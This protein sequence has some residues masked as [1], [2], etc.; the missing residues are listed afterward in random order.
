MSEE[1]GREPTDEDLS[2]E[3]GI[4]SAKLSQLKTVSIRPSSVDAPLSDDDSTAFAEIV[5]DEDA[6]TP[7][8]L[9]RDKNMR[10]ELSVL[11]EVSGHRWPLRSGW[12]SDKAAM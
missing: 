8:E 6:R 12:P 10:D 1:L 7:F 3:I 5:G 9:F 11:L 2:E 4:S